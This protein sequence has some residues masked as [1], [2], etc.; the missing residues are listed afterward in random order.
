MQ[1]MHKMFIDTKSVI[2]KKEAFNLK[3]LEEVYQ[4]LTNYLGM[5][6]EEISK[7]YWKKRLS[8]DKEEQR[9]IE[10]ASNQD[11]A[12]DY[13]RNTHQYLY[14]LSIWEAQKDKQRE[15]KKIY[16]FCKKRNIKKILDFGGGVGGLC[17]YLNNCGLSCDYLDIPGKTYDFARR[18]FD[19]RKMN[20]KLISAFEEC[21]SLRYDA[22]VAYDVFEH[23]FDLPPA[24]KKINACL[25]DGGY[26]ISKSTFSGGG[27]HLLKN[28]IY[29]DF[30]KFNEL[31]QR[32]GFEFIGQLKAGRF[33]NLLNKIGLKY[34]LFSIRLKERHK[35]GGNFIV[36][37]KR[38]DLN[39]A[40][41]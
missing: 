40:N 28:E 29:Q 16:L 11:K 23:I 6:I 18:R 21:L 34:L 8:T 24:L 1:K 22:V 5:P 19:R 3:K 4:D 37:R 10:K 9:L 36:H 25:S 13:Y 33:N 7:D 38:V 12:I 35:Y 26:L 41:G 30:N 27:L 31:L 15:F 2:G 20:L 32:S 39:Y 14:E 17:I